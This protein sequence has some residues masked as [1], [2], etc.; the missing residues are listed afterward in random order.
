MIILII[1]IIIIFI[2]FILSDEFYLKIKFEFY[3]TII[4]N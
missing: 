2:N 3:N 4:I 1:I